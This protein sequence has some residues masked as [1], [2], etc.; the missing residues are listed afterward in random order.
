MKKMELNWLEGWFDDPV[1][2]ASGAGVYVIWHPLGADNPATVYVG[3]GQI[4]QRLEERRYDGRLV[5]FRRYDLLVSC[6]A[7]P[8]DQRDGVERY[9]AH[10]LAPKVG[11]KWPDAEPIV[12]NLPF[13]YDIEIATRMLELEAPED[14]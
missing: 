12:V 6:A 10:V 11:E 5:H 9:L 14:T 3:Q 7:V 8:E 13:T 1:S 2:P 4:A